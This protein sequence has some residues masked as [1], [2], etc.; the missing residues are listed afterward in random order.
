MVSSVGFSK[1]LREEATS[2]THPGIS[3]EGALGHHT[4]QVGRTRKAAR[5]WGKK[6]QEEE[7]GLRGVCVCVG[8]ATFHPA[9]SRFL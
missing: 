6:I 2:V 9:N 1:G 8:G 3:P 4:F 7:T 5:S